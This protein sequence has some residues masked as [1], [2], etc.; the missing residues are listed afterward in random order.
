MISTN[1]N[2]QNRGSARWI[3]YAVTVAADLVLTVILKLIEPHLPLAEFPIPYVL[4]TLMAAYL[5]GE[6]SAILAF[7]L[8]LICYAYFFPPYHGLW[9]P[10]ATP[11]DWAGLVAFG[12]GNLGVAFVTIAMR[13]GMARARML[14][15]D[16]GRTEAQY[17]SLI[18]TMNEGFATADADYV[19]TYVNARFAEMLGYM[20]EE[21][22]GRRLEE[23]LDETSRTIM[24]GQIAQRRAGRY[25]RYELTWLSKDDRPVRAL[26]S[27]RPV[28]D[29]DGRFAGSFGAVTDITELKRA[30]E[31]KRFFYRETIFS[32]TEGK[33]DICE[34]A[35][36][37]PYLASSEIALEIDTLERLSHVRH[38]VEEF[39]RAH[40]LSGDALGLFVIA[41][42]EAMTN[43]VKHATQARVYSGHRDGSVWVGVKDSGP[44]IES[45]IIPRAVLLR[46]FST[47]PSL[48]LGYSLMLG[49]ADR[50]HL[51][52]D[53]AGTVVIL[54]KRLGDQ[55][56]RI[57]PQDLP[58][59]WGSILS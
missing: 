23:F 44:G 10:A 16:L 42:G 1:E 34:Q 37:A 59:T 56:D 28:F 9:P 26:V 27:P 25:G 14:A 11:L 3:G 24:A 48:G 6:V 51:K 50:I 47:K 55:R 45:L 38:E 12:L 53:A 15:A 36:V 32:V 4:V 41:V 43:A 33:L 31:Q 49:V 7:V 30:E 18:E 19:F 21:M 8:G 29:S 39:C 20:P 40:G 52:T 46:G 2:A 22:I 54:E 57:F 5:F 17:R 35:D 13:R 58:D